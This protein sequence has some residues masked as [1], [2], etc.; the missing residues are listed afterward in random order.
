MV[1]TKPSSK[2]PPQKKAHGSPPRRKNAPMP[3]RKK[4]L[5]YQLTVQAFPEPFAFEKYIF[6]YG[7]DEKDG[8]LYSLK[9]F[10]SGNLEEN[11]QT[12]VDANVTACPDHRIPFSNDEV[13]KD[14]DNVYHRCIIV[15]YPKEGESTPETRI[16]GLNLL[17]DFFMDHNFSKFPPAFIDKSDITD[18]DNPSPLDMFFLDKEIKDF[19]IQAIDEKYLNKTFVATFPE[20]AKLCWSGKHISVF[21]QSLGFE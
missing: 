20:F 11:P 16:T 3:Q 8:F 12:L 4:K 17:A 15:R 5:S 6:H 13:L 18:L 19:I 9:Q 10:L 7:N 21:A 2:F 14:A 1:G